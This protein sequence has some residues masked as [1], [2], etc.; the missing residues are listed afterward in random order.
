MRSPRV[1]VVGGGITGLSL[2]FTLQDDA[3]RTGAPL[4]LTVLEAATRFG[5]HACTAASD[6]F[7]VEAGPN[8]FLDREPHTLA[9]IE[10]LGL[11]PRI[12]HARPEAKR[13]FILRNGRLCP[14]PD[15][16]RTLLSSGTLSWR[17]KLRLLAE[18]FAPG[19]PEGIDETIFEFAKRRI[20]REA[21]EM[22][23]D[24]AVSG[25]SAGDSRQ[26]SVAAQF[27]RM[28]EMERE[29]GSLI[30]AM[31]A[32]R[33]AGIGA[34]RL[35]SFDA[36]MGTLTGALAGRLGPSLWTDARVRS[37]ERAGGVWRLVV[38][39][40]RT[41]DADHV[42]FAAPA[43]TVAPLVANLDSVL[44]ASLRAVGYAGI[45]MVALGYRLT[46]VPRPLDGYGYLVTRAERLAT[47]GV[48]WESSLFPGRAPDGM[49]LLRVFLGG[50]R[51]PDVLAMDPQEVEE[52]ARTELAQVMGIRAAAGRSWVFT[53]P[54]AIAQ[55]TVGHR[56]RRARIHD[57]LSRHPGL[58]VCGT[59]YDGVSF[60]DAIKSGRLLAR[61]LADRLWRS[62]AGHA[63]DLE[64][65]TVGA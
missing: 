10:A 64:P 19:P 57:R 34:P 59:S 14:A 37:V 6:G 52:V 40:G 39:D 55:Y 26:L 48:V 46:D 30:R 32:R 18:P 54:G 51:R 16:P 45:A 43:R 20:G 12:V 33:K 61:A 24:A 49:A 23:V 53:W 28:V 36:G 13:R 65:V 44:A 41:V 62:D 63:A 35:L 58:S 50:A 3:S 11:G 25:I 42:V 8:G 21:A 29:H 47:L 38:S 60:N 7:L 4:S 1:A 2:A 15:S 9:L 27:P 56:E 5:G 31:I 17:G 22:L